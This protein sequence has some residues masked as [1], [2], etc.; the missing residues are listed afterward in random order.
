MPVFLYHK[1]LGFWLEI[2]G[3]VISI[4]LYLSFNWF[5]LYLKGVA[6]YAI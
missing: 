1:L 2:D 6:S 3:L 5:C 4:Y